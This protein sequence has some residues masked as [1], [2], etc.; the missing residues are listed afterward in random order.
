MSG[1]IY[2][3]Y[4]QSVNF[5]EGSFISGRIL[6]IKKQKAERNL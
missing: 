1:P 4:S 3:T 6:S 5:L 2:K